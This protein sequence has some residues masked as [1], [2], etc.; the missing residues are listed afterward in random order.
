MGASLPAAVGDAAAAA[1]AAPARGVVAALAGRT[2]PFFGE[3]DLPAARASSSAPIVRDPAADAGRAALLLRRAAGLRAVLSAAASLLRELVPLSVRDMPA[4]LGR[5][6]LLPGRAVAAVVVS[7]LRLPL[8]SAAAAGAAVPCG[9]CGGCCSCCETAYCAVVAAVAALMRLTKSACCC[10][11]SRLLCL[12]EVL[13]DSGGSCPP[14][15]KGQS[16]RTLDL[17]R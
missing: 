6:R 4:V 5:P 9:D 1:A 2:P 11:D 16:T 15:G 14:A 13:G 3:G 10:T 7:D 8:V 17:C 12:G